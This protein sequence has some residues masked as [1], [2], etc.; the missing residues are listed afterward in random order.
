MTVERIAILETEA[1]HLR[2]DIEELK[3]Q[4]ASANAKLDRLVAA[5]NMAGGAW[6]ASVKIGGLI[7]VALGALAWIADH[8]PRLWR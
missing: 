5:A 2:A 3:V 8:V 7:L 1:R 4:L 6:F